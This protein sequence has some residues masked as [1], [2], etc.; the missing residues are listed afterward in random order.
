VDE[1]QAEI[2][3]ALRRIPGLRVAITSAVGDGFPDITVGYRGA[4]FFFEIK[5]PSKP[6]RDQR[7]TEEQEKWHAA[8]TGQVQTVR[9][10]KEI[11]T[12]LTGWQP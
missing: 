1:N 2:V 7:L 8:W 12:T 11:I 4:N 3:E 5:D 10:L 6:L 9:G